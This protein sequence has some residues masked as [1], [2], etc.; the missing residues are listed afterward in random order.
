MLTQHS[1]NNGA[2]DNH[3]NFIIIVHV[4]FYNR[5]KRTD[6]RTGNVKQVSQATLDVELLLA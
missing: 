5:S 4:Q 1:I 2:I 6:K 3:Y